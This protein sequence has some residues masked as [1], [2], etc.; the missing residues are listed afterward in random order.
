[1]N[2]GLKSEI[3][4]RSSGDYHVLKHSNSTTTGVTKTR[5]SIIND[6][7]S[8]TIKGVTQTVLSNQ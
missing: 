7:H 3:V 2:G 4:D 1:M 5:F 6:E 8:R